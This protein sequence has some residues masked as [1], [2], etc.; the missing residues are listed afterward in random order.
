M[1]ATLERR[2]S[3]DPESAGPLCSVLAQLAIATPTE[4][5]KCKHIL[6]GD[7]A[8]AHKSSSGVV[9]KGNHTVFKDSPGLVRIEEMRL[10]PTCF[11]IVWGHIA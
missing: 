3:E 9:P 4:L 8:L 5:Q 1:F 6:N 11:E 10:M 7:A 2:I